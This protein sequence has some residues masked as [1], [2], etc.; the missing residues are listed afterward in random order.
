[1]FWLLLQLT[2]S[3]R[4][5]A[6][7]ALLYGFATPVLYRTAQLNHNLLVGHFAL[8]AFAL[9]WHPWDIAER[10]RRASHLLAGLLAG[11]AVVLDYSGIAVLLPLGGYALA[12]WMLSPARSRSTSELLLFAVGAAASLGVLAAYQWLAFGSPLA[13]AQRMMP[14]TFLSQYGYNGMD[15]PQPDLLWDTT[16]GLRFG[17]FTSAPLLLLAL[18]PPGWRRKAGRLLERRELW[19]VAAVCV[20]FFLFAS[21]NQFGRLQ[22]NSGVR[23]VVPVVPFLF[24]VVA[25]VLLKL[26]RP[27]AVAIGVATAYMSWCLALYR[28]V[29]QG[30]GV[31]ESLIHVSTGGPELPWITT[32]DRLGYL[33]AGPASLLVLAL[34]VAAVC[35]IWRGQLPSLSWWSVR[36]R[37]HATTPTT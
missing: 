35:V 36:R 15:W 29:E 2:G 18:Y 10:P 14:P 37:R 33:P 19:F 8:F 6:W 34:T 5:S 25:G 4:A 9:L 27:L 26:P 30:L 31:L 32:L 17:L 28:D 11:W 7:L 22:F 13:P 1:M 21:A 16:F 3:T 20:L 12:R 23:Y 24:L